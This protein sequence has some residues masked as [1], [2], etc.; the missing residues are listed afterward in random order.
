MIVAAAAAH[1]V[2]LERAKSRRGL[3]CAN[4]AGLGMS[5]ARGEFGGRGRDTG[6]VTEIIKCNALGAENG[7]RIAGN[8]HQRSAG[9]GSRSVAGMRRDC[10]IGRQAAE[11]R[12]DERQAGDHA[13]FAHDDES[14]AIRVLRHGSG[15]GDVAGAPEIFLKRARDRRL[16]FERGQKSIG[17]QKR[18][19]QTPWQSKIP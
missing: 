8:R 17:A 19:R 15:G 11:S 13:G 10:D 2:F 6:K 5:D 3:A 7:A 1:R 4:D 14:A 18:H 16:D 9:P 12:L